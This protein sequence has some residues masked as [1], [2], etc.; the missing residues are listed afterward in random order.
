[1]RRSIPRLQPVG[2]SSGEGA[3]GAAAAA[4]EAVYAE[5]DVTLQHRMSRRK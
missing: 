4:E 3:A 1:M 5:T 2:R